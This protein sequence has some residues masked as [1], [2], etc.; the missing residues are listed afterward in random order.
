MSNGIPIFLIE[1]QACKQ[2]YLIENFITDMRYKISVY[3][4]TRKF[5]YKKDMYTKGQ[6]RILCGNCYDRKRKINISIKK[7]NINW[8]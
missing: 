8:I 1:C 4:E 2:E 6:Q 5:L 3:S 7:P